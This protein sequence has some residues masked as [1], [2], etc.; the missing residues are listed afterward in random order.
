MSVLL[1]AAVLIISD[2]ATNDPSTDKCTEALKAVFDENESTTI[3]RFVERRFVPDDVLR[4]QGAITRWTDDRTGE[5]AINLIVCSG[6]TGFARRDVTPEVRV[7]P[8][9]TNES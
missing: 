2:T 1:K 7:A 4:I 3:L 6:G 8:S 5:D 9:T